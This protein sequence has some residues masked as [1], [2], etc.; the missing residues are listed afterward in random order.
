[1]CVCEA[2]E[3]TAA[4]LMVH[5]LSVRAACAVEVDKEFTTHIVHKS[6]YLPRKKP[7]VSTE[8]HSRG[9]AVYRA[10]GVV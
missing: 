4:V 9:S 2:G 5:R 7:V 3:F 6:R 10:L 1:M 8:W